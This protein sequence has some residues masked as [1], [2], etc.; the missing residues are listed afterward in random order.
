MRNTSQSS[1]VSMAFLR[2]PIV[3]SEGTISPFFSM[4]LIWLPVSEPLATSA[5]SKSPAE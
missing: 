5:R 2:R 3:T 4:S 1:V